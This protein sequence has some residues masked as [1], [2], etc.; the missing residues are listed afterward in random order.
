MRIWKAFPLFVLLATLGCASLSR[1]PLKIAPVFVSG[2]AGYHTYRIPAI[3]VTQKGT[4]LAFCEGRKNS[5][6]DT[7]DIDLVWKR[8]TDGGKTWSAQKILWSDGANTCGNPAPVIDQTTGIIW[9]LMTWNDGADKEDAIKLQKARNTRRV[10]V[11]SS[12]DDGLTWAAPREITASTKR[13]EWGWYATGPCHGIQL[14]RGP[15]KNRLVIPANHSI[16]GD[17]PEAATRSHVIFSDDHGKTWQLGGIEEEKTNE[18]TIVE[19]SDGTLMHNMR[20]YHGKNRRAVATS[21]DAGVTWSPVKL[22]DALIEPVCQG[23]ILRH[24][25]PDGAD[26]GCI[27]FSNPASTKREKMTVRA[28]YDEGK[29]WPAFREIFAGPAAY[30]DLAVLPDKSIGCLFECGATNAYE[31]ISLARFPLRQLEESP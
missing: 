4:V 25:G 26:K 14:T 23:S 31:T 30:S 8:S 27:L 7:G 1:D 18:S 24:T 21:S 16:K 28:S 6:S 22:D 19:L 9:L 5:R 12:A 29:T 2:Q 13:P 20:S 15:H 11:T 10:F 3:I 17:A